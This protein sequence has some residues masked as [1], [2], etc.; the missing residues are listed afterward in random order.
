MHGEI[1]ELEEI[2]NAL[3]I[4]NLLKIVNNDQIA[5]SMDTEEYNKTMN[6]L[7]TYAKLETKKM[8]KNKDF[9]ELVEELEESS[10]QK[11]R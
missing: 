8:L 11:S 2:K 5:L 10:K 9:K 4:S 6:V 1:T 3:V 7:V